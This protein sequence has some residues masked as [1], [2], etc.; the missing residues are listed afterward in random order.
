MRI[1]PS[2]A[3]RP[4]II[5]VPP[6]ASSSRSGVFG[7]LYSETRS[8][9][10]LEGEEVEQRILKKLK[11]ALNPTHL[12]AQDTSGGLRSLRCLGAAAEHIGYLRRLWTILQCRH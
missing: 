12:A 6:I 4:S 10:P 7:R 8:G 2:I 3:F 5:T 9:A 11:E 1:L